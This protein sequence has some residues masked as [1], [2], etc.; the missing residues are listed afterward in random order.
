ML[1]A[2]ELQDLSFSFSLCSHLSLLDS[3]FLSL[4]LALTA[5]NMHMSE[6]MQH[7]KGKMPSQKQKKEKPCRLSFF[8]CCSRFHTS[9]V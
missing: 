5:F 7:V 3:L 6:L 2:S 8:V 9:T 1:R 4:F